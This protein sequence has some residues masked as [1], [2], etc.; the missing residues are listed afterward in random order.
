MSQTDSI[1][2]TH[3]HQVCF[4]RVSFDFEAKT[5]PSR[6]GTNGFASSPAPPPVPPQ[7]GATPQLPT[8]VGA[9][10]SALKHIRMFSHIFSSYD[11]HFLMI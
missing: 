10:H 9:A 6:D 3:N 11:Y 4:L 8:Q 1:Y 2:G 7:L 5:I